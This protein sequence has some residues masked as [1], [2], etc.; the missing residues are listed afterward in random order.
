MSQHDLAGDSRRSRALI[1]ELRGETPGSS[2][3]LQNRR[4]R[5]RQESALVG[6]L[7]VREGDNPDRG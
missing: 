5:R 6:K 4:H 3:K 2:V 7:T 1:G